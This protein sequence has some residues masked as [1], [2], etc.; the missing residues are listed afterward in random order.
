M[1]SLEAQLRRLGRRRRTISTIEASALAALSYIAF[2]QHDWIWGGI[3]FAVA[4]LVTIVT[5]ALAEYSD[6]LWLDFIR[7]LRDE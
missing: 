1:G 3:G 6:A 7:K 5:E 2:A 4:S